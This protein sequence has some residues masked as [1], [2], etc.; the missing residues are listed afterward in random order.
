MKANQASSVRSVASTQ[1]LE[2]A[3]A[4]V[5]A[6]ARGD[7][8]SPRR[9][10]AREARRQ[11]RAGRDLDQLLVAALDRAFAL[12]E[13]GEAAVPVAKDLDLDVAGAGDQALGVER[14]VAEGAR[15]LRPA[16]GE[17]L[18]DLGLARTA[19][20]PRPPPP[21]TALSMIGRADRRRRTP[22]PPRRRRRRR[23]RSPAR[24]RARPRARGARACRRR[25]RAPAATGR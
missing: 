9:R 6:P 13:V 17:G 24:P 1:E 3:E 7:P 14:T 25:G 19:R 10:S 22:A 12:A 16:A 15:R 18:G 23:P 21:A 2:R 20:M 5:V 11:R 8:S 4:V